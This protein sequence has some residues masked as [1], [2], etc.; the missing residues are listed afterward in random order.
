MVKYVLMD[1]FA[2]GSEDIHGIYSNRADAEADFMDLCEEWVY[3]VMMTEDTWD[4]FGKE[5]WDWKEDYNYLMRDCA[6]TLMIV[7]VPYYD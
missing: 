6:R 4:V 3:E 2:S 1:Y 5:K 7:E